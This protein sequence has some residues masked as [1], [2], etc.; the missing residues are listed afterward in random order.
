LRWNE[1]V[2]QALNIQTDFPDI[3]I[4]LSICAGLL[5]AAILYFR[6]TKN[7]FAR[8]IRILLFFLR[9]AASALLFFL[10]LAPMVQ[11]QKKIIEK[12]KIIIFTDAS[13]SIKARTDSTELLAFHEGMMQL[14]NK[15]SED[16]QVDAFTFGDEI[17]EGWPALFQE[18]TSEYSKVPGFI[19]E[20]YRGKEAAA[21]IWAG[22]GIFNRGTNPI[23][24]TKPLLSK[25]YTIAL[26]DSSQTT[27]LVLNKLNY[28]KKAYLN[29]NFPLEVVFQADGLKGKKIS[30]I[31]SEN[32]SILGTAEQIIPSSA[33]TG[34]RIFYFKAEK[35]GY[36]QLNVQ[37]LTESNETSSDNNQASAFIEVTSDRKKV[38]M[39]YHAPH[40]DVAAIQNALKGDFNIDFSSGTYAEMKDSMGGSNLVILHQ[41]PSLK[42]NNPSLFKTIQENKIAVLY[43]LGSQSNIS[44]FNNLQTLLQIDKA[45]NSFDDARIKLNEAFSLFLID[46]STLKATEEWPP[47]LCPFGEYLPSSG[48]STLFYQK[49]G[50][51]N[52]TR[53]MICFGNANGQRSGIIAGEGIWRWRIANFKNNQSH[54]DFDQIIRKMVHF[55]SLHETKKAFK[56]NIADEINENENIL[57]N[58]VLLNQNNEPDNSPELQIELVDQNDKEF[59]FLFS[60]TAHTYSLNIGRLP[61]GTYT[62]K[63]SVQLAGKTYQENGK[64]YIRPVQI[65]NT[66]LRANHRL[67]HQLAAQ[68]EGKMFYPGQLDELYSEIINQ[69]DT[70]ETISFRK[71]NRPITD[72]WWIAGL[73]ILWLSL[74]WFVRKRNGSY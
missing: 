72:F 25:I 12:P 71:K 43:I 66:Q 61:A 54:N 39:I 16:F 56:L 2:T 17:K 47:L 65:E 14:S 31:I 22:D 49:I 44:T 33:Y 64:I 36:R 50:R 27:D 67:M 38:C 35:K 57:A 11:N 23:Y 70:K 21:I 4:P 68:N 8:P 51:V 69:V 59:V 40:P 41:I 5:F 73:I 45:Q 32:D 24:S 9:F 62:W 3:F 10:L 19:N 55:L 48:T 37:L 58:A 53:P 34:N 60:R 30:I 46:Q 26:G 7:E 74:E 13:E 1:N 52:S 18:K 28:N 6:E 29:N 63:S 42:N 15:L 20:Q